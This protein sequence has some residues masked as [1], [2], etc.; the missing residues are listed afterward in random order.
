MLACCLNPF[1]KQMTFIGMSTNSIAHRLSLMGR[2]YSIRR[3]YT[4]LFPLFSPPFLERVSKPLFPSFPQSF[5]IGLFPLFRRGAHSCR[6]KSFS[7]LAV[8]LC[9]IC[10]F[11]AP[12]CFRSSR[13]QRR[14]EPIPIQ[15]WA[16]PYI[17]L[18]V[19]YALYLLYLFYLL[20][21][22]YL[23]YLLY[24]LYPLYLLYLLNTWHSQRELNVFRDGS[25]AQQKLWYYNSCC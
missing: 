19:L 25:R 4:V 7:H 17:S 1:W 10:I 16:L 8:G 12:S 3:F 9:T 20:Y 6:H 18:V 13:L 24:L 22:L 2:I 21:P 5:L 14:C 23:L 11:Y 15:L